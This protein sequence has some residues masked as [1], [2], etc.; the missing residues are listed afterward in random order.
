MQ[1]SRDPE[2]VPHLSGDSSIA[3][4]SEGYRFGMHRFDRLG[5][6]AFSTRLMLRPV[7]F[8]R[9]ADAARFFY[10]GE[11]FTRDR[12]MPVSVLH[13]LQDEGSVQTL[14]GSQHHTRK[15]MFSDMVSN[16]AMVTLV[17]IFREEWMRAVV[18]WSHRD[19]IVL[20]TELAEVLTRTACSWAG[21]PL[22]EDEV[23]DRSSEFLAMIDRAGTYGP[24]NWAAR[25]LRLRTEA[26]AR[27]VVRTAAI[28]GT[29]PAGSPLATIVHHRELDGEPLDDRT[30]AIEL[31]NVLRPTVAVGRFIVF[32]AW[33]L[34]RHP[35]WAA[36]F[37][38]GDDQHLEA[39]VQEVRRFS[40]FFPVVGGRA[41]DDLQWRGHPIGAGEWVMLDLFATNRH[42]ALWEDPERFD[43]GRF[44]GRQVNRNVLVPQGGGY[45]ADGHRC[46]GE[47]PTV[48][49]IAEAVRLLTTS[50]TYDVPPQDLRV[51]LRRMPAL[52]QS[53]F[54]MT[55]VR[56]R[57]PESSA[58]VRVTDAESTSEA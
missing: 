34:R 55:G 43:P 6:D 52:P 35:R 31:L 32:A 13:S 44:V 40:P 24:P 53:G 17:A 11:R 46:P 29:A 57:R 36:R 21:A 18:R 51:D 33:A 9:G 39:F 22:R 20:H 41:A 19:S 42:P 1:S 16:A 58:S 15:G 5:S 4:L 56:P 12:A 48:D 7:T 25:A 50:M 26:W 54:V 37:A 27:D 3:F 30:A 23:A 38:A 2:P 45:A 28:E 14:S 8:L 10:E 47:E 49:L